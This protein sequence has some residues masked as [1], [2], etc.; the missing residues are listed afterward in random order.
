MTEVVIGGAVQVLAHV[1]GLVRYGSKPS[2]EL[3]RDPQLWPRIRAALRSFEDAVGYPPHQAYLG[4]LH[5]RALPPRPHVGHRLE[6]ADRWGAFGELMSELEFLGLL[7]LVDEF[8]LVALEPAVAEASAGAL[9]SHPVCRSLPLDRLTATTPSPSTSVQAGALPLFLGG[10]DAPVGSVRAAHAEDEAL[11]AP[12]LLE[13]LACKATA[14]LALR[15]L[16]DRYG[17][18]PDSIEYV[19]SCSEEAVGDRYQRGGGNMAKAVAT[20]VGLNEA[21]GCDVKDFCAAPIPAIVAAAALVHAG[22][23]QRVAVVAGGSL[24]KLGMKFEGHLRHGLPILEDVL[25]GAAL[26]VQADDGTSPR[27]R[28]DVVGRHRVASGGAN[29]Q[30]M[31]DLAIAP[32]ERIGLRLTDVDVV[33]TELHDPEVTEP[34]GSGDVAARNYRAL[35]AVAARAGHIERSAVEAFI[36]QVGMP[37]FAPTQGHLASALCYL[38]HALTELTS[39]GARRVLLMA[40]G[41][42]FLG[43]MSQASDGMSVL[44]ERN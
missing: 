5:P 9:T 37:G 1:P 8:D 7:A 30:I 12:V 4:R 28:L 39:G 23:F 33:A 20:S 10:G 36:S 24:P 27:V 15:W 25:G 18:E 26:L 21:S 16:L 3:R 41:S 17:F 19:I 11:S 31:Q 42:L 32:L 6:G 13:N 14:V 22:V 43:R 40:K 35:A 34:Q 38:P 29:P 44:L 2:R